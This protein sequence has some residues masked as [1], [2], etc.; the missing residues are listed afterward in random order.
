MTAIEKTGEI[1]IAAVRGSVRFVS[2]PRAANQEKWEAVVQPN[3]LQAHIREHYENVG[4]VSRER[5]PACPE[6]P[7]RWHASACAM[8]K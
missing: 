7:H 1:S 6:H 3:Y 4:A 2:P 8:E 5:K